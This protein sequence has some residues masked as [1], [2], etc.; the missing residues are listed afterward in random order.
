MAEILGNE[1][2]ELDGPG[3]ANAQSRATEPVFGQAEEK[4][5]GWELLREFEQD[6]EQERLHESYANWL[7]ARAGS[8]ELKGGDR[9]DV[10]GSLKLL[11]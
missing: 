6:L 3:G 5:E 10:L 11:N 2:Q 7:E 8:I 4:N 1:A 9:T